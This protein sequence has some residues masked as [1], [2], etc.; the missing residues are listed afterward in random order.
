MKHKHL[1]HIIIFG[2][3]VL[4]LLLV[5][6][7]YW[8]KRAFDIS[9]KQFDF[10]V[11]IALKKVADSVL[12]NSEANVEVQKLSSNF[13]FIHCEGPLE[14]NHVEQLIQREFSLR[15]L[16]LDYELGIYRADKD[17]LVYGNYIQSTTAR[18]LE[19]EIAK[20][21]FNQPPLNNFAVYFP[22]KTSYLAAEMDIWILSTLALALMI[23]FFA[24]A[25]FSLLREKRY[26]DV[27]T[28]FINNMTH[29]FKTPVTNIA[30]AS[31]VLKSKYGT[32]AEDLVYFKILEKENKKL[33]QKIDRL[34]SSAVFEKTSIT[35]FEKINLRH[36]L[37][38]CAQT[39][40]M[41]IKER[42]GII[43]ID[44]P[45]KDVQVYGDS[46]LLLQAFSNIIDNAEKY[47]LHNPSI[48]I[49]SILEEKGII[50]SF[51]DAGIGIPGKWHRKVFDKFFRFRQGNVHNVKGFGLGLHFVRDVIKAHQGKILLKSAANQGTTVSIF[52]PVV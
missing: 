12:D 51:T 46:G 10:T 28:D 39:F 40:E 2:S 1:R 44:L 36:I 3:L 4:S 13:F 49:K 26:A 15:N 29:E 18:M 45:E 8:F 24:W 20:G 37:T 35:T 25:I 34:L 11:Q 6:Q 48:H 38:E 9:E 19:E 23:I 47:S 5:V 14:A 21:R 32:S 42:G 27:K 30:L 43:H 31:E 17:T 7:V 52:L 41:K 16:D 33:Q 22:H 50:I